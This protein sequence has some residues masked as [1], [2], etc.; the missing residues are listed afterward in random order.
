MKAGGSLPPRDETHLD[1]KAR[2]T[3]R[4]WKRNIVNCS[5]APPPLIQG[6]SESPNSR[7][8]GGREGG[9]GKE[10]GGKKMRTV[11]PSPCPT[12]QAGRKGHSCVRQLGLIPT[13]SFLNFNCNF[14]LS[15]PQPLYAPLLNGIFW[16]HFHTFFF[17]DKVSCA[18]GWLQTHRVAEV[19]LELLFLP[20]LSS[21]SYGCLPPR[22]A[23][24]PRY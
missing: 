14:Q 11:L 10:R 4:R 18:M 1:N 13:S 23:R 15:L 21:N 2:L 22:S 24:L 6:A 20:P 3:T 17:Q 7:R 9:R 16:T 8:K 19:D 12:H 5:E